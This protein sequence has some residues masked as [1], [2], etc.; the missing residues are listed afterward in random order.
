ML[1]PT[2][3]AK[4]KTSGEMLDLVFSPQLRKSGSPGLVPSW[5]DE[6]CDG[7]GVINRGSLG[8]WVTLW[9]RASGSPGCLLPLHS[10]QREESTSSYCLEAF[11][12]LNLGKPNP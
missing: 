3:T 5:L 2:S 11:H 10:E 12:N 1:S 4:Q 9:S 8:S 6:H 7:G